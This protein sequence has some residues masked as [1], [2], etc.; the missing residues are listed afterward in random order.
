MRSV[1]EAGSITRPFLMT[2]D[3]GYP[4]T[5]SSTAMRTA[6]PF[7]TWFRITDRCEVGHLRGELAPAID[8]SGMHHDGVRLGQLQV[9]QPQA[10]ELEIF[11]GRKRRLRAAAPAARA[12][13]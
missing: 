2:I 7:S 12:A 13:S 9:L 3:M 1:F 5:F 8:G 6:M 4:I 11:A 10:V